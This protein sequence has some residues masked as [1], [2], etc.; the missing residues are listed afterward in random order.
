MEKEASCAEKLLGCTRFQTL[1]QN[2]VRV[3]LRR[4]SREGSLGL[5]GSFLT[6]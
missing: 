4:V 3:R 6:L 5:R 2:G 1:E